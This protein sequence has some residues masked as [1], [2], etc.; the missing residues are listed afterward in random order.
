MVSKMRL[1]PPPKVTVPPP[2]RE[3]APVAYAPLPPPRPFPSY[4]VLAGLIWALRII[5][6][7]AIA[8]AVLFF[9]LIILGAAKA[10]GGNGGAMIVVIIP[11]VGGP[12]VAGL[13]LFAMGELLSCVRDMAIN[14]FRQL[15]R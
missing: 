11:T 6:G 3:V 15:Q 12:L 7:I 4:A 5:G 2:A 9:G 1:M 8:M 14:S 13:V 10:G